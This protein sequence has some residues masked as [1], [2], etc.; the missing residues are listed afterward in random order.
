M[1]DFINMGSNDAFMVW[2]NGSI[3][4]KETLKNGKMTQSLHECLKLFRLS[5]KIK[6]IFL[7]FVRN[8]C[9]D[10]TKTA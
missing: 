2:F 1:H 6:N 8:S 7:G 10:D 3:H 4:A 5:Y 9:V